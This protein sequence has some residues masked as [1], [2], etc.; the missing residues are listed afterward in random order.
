MYQNFIT[1]RDIEMISQMGLN[2]IR[3]P[4]NHTLLEDDAHP[5]QYKESGWKF[6]D[7]LLIWSEKH[8]VYVV[9]DLHSAPGGCGGDGGGYSWC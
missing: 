2:V 9:L 8:R 3:V 6:L 5:Y 4:F 1:E 7:Q